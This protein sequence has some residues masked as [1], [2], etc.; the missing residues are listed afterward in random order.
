[1][2]PTD[3][4]GPLFHLSLQELQQL[5]FEAFRT[6]RRD[7]IDAV[8]SE[9]KKR[10]TPSAVRLY[11]EIVRF[12][13]HFPAASM[14]AEAKAASVASRDCKQ[15]NSGA[16]YSSPSPTSSR[17]KPSLTRE[18]QEAIALFNEGKTLKVN[19]FA[20]A[21]KTTTLRSM[22]ASTSRKGLYLAFN[23]AVA[24]YAGTQFPQNVR[25]RTVHSAAYAYFHRNLG[26]HGKRAELVNHHLVSRIL[27]IEDVTFRNLR[28]RTR[29]IAFLVRATLKAYFHSD[30]VAIS[31]EHVPKW[32]LLVKLSPQE[33]RD[34]VDLVIRFA[35]QLWAKM[36]DGKDPT[37]IDHDGYVKYWA[38]CRPMLDLDF[39]LLDEA[40]DVNPVVL[41]VLGR[42]NCQVVYVGDRHQQ[43]Y[44]WRGAI[45]AMEKINAPH[46]AYLSQSFR[47]GENI[48]V[49]ANR[50]LAHLQ[51]TRT[52][53][54]MRDR[55]SVRSSQR[56]AP[57]ALLCRT[58]AKLFGKLLQVL[59]ANERPY[60]EG[61]CDELTRLLQGVQ[62]LQRGRPSCEPELFGY[63]DWKSFVADA[64]A[65][66]NSSQ[67]T[68]VMLVNAH[69]ADQLLEVLKHVE[70]KEQ[71][72]TI[73]LSTAHKAKGREWS[74]V[75]LAED[76][77]IPSATASPLEPPLPREELRINYVAVTRAQESLRLPEY[78][79]QWLSRK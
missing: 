74:N 25:C 52:I 37:P 30:D 63:S 73:A 66:E 10:Q 68:L 2:T 79:D 7:M 11:D 42:Q 72:A 17:T 29:E 62:D 21:G 70:S 69:G 27:Q 34:L 12:S 50:V 60:I 41:D 28:V 45:N 61:G 40:Q 26:G 19:A 6:S 4:F 43:I 77:H 71:T 59:Q 18:Q 3:S 15:T 56:G 9:L 54:G 51:E 53:T 75:E 31:H 46:S 36:V 49:K 8:L 39:I 76:F 22:A 78:F 48:A 20:G 38:L 64:Y 35:N 13:S 44:E 58:N 47:F 67:K 14:Q 23:R 57:R 32:G 24:D 5:V 33:W 55:I 16:E 1:M 65:E